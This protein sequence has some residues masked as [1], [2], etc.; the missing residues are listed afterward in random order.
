MVCT[1]ALYMLLQME[2]NSNRSLC[3]PRDLSKHKRD[4]TLHVASK[5]H[6]AAWIQ[7][8]FDKY[9]NRIH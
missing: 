6:E 8:H 1:L 5:W 9:G 4:A 7:D 2:L 3:I